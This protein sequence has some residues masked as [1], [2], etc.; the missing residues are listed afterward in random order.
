MKLFSTPSLLIGAGVAC[1][2]DI[3]NGNEG[4]TLHCSEIPACPACN[5]Q[6]SIDYETLLKLESKCANQTYK[7][8]DWSS[9]NNE[10]EIHVSANF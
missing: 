10:K 9:K 3:K 4:N 6:P 7:I 2:Y 8:L 1:S 5:C